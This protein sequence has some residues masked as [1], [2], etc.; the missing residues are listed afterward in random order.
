MEHTKQTPNE[1]EGI[2]GATSREE[3]VDGDELT[4]EEAGFMQGY[5]ES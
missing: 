2:Y 5:M 1:E 4:P 3:L